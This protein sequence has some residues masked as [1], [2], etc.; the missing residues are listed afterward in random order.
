MTTPEATA[1]AARVLTEAT[2]IRQATKAAELAAMP[3][4][5]WWLDVPR[6]TFAAV[7]AGQ[8]ARMRLSRE[9]RRLAE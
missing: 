1:R 5:S 7:V 9:G 4:A 2:R 6:E 3:A 8:L